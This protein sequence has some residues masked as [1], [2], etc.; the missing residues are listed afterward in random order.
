MSAATIELL[1]SHSLPMLLEREI[2]Q[3][4]L[5]GQ[6]NPGDR[7][8]EKEL[9]LRFG[10]SR[11]PV[12][13]ALRTLEATGLVEQIPNRGV[14]VRQLTAAQADDIYEVR[15]ALFALAG[16]LLAE[17]ATDEEIE[18]LR[19]F[20]RAMDI[21]IEKDN[22]D[23]YARENFALH[24][25]IVERAGNGTLAGQYLALI[26]QLRL[27]RARSLMF[28]NAMLASN[29]EHHEMVEAIAARDPERAYAAH[30]RHVAAAKI[31]LKAHLG[32]T[33]TGN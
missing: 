6:F 1:R 27:Y 33:S 16:R 8:N 12:R 11:G 14:F 20:V 5:N 25:Y 22:F 31:R 30:H 15:A 7:I 4:I 28:G 3:V 23:S 21:A 18:R 26:K 10:I 19:A 13:E 32:V 24:E 2:E 9:A 29:A 17:R